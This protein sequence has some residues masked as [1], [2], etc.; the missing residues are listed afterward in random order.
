M[1]STDTQLMSESKMCFHLLIV[2]SCFNSAK[3]KFNLDAWVSF[4]SIM[5]TCFVALQNILDILIG[6]GFLD[7]LTEENWQK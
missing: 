6:F 5:I 1:S 4:K 2:C 3:I 7:I